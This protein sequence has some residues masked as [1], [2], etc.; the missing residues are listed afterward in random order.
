[1]SNGSVSK[2]A[3]MTA[4]ADDGAAAAATAAATAAPAAAATRNVKQ[5][6]G[7]RKH[8]GTE[9][10][11]ALKQG[12]REHGVGNWSALLTNPSIGPVLAKRSYVNLKD[13]WRSMLSAKR[14]MDPRSCKESPFDA[15]GDIAGDNAG[16][17]AEA[18]RNVK[19]VAGT[20]KHWGTEEV[21][22][23]KQG[24]RE[25]GVGNWSALLT[26]PSI[27]PV[28]AKR[29]YVNLK[30][31]WRSMLNAK[32]RMDPRSCKESPFDAAGDIAGDNAGDNAE[33]SR[34]DTFGTTKAFRDEAFRN[35]H[36]ASSDM[37][38]K[39]C[40][41]VGGSSHADF[42][43]GIGKRA[44]VAPTLAVA[45]AAG[46]ALAPPLQQHQMQQ[47]QM[48][49]HQM[50]QHRMQQQA[51][52]G[53]A[54]CCMHAALCAQ[55]DA[56]AR[57][58][59]IS[60]VLHAAQSRRCLACGAQSP[61]AI[62]GA[63]AATVSLDPRRTVAY[64]PGPLSGAGAVTGGTGTRVEMPAAAADATSGAVA[65]RAGAVAPGQALPAASAS[66]RP[67]QQ[68]QQQQQ[69]NRVATAAWAW[70]GPWPW[71]WPA[72]YNPYAGRGRQLAQSYMPDSAQQQLHQ[73]LPQPYGQ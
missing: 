18:T 24:V 39:R 50:Q 42:A 43:G 66:T 19:Q 10:V 36:S 35:E 25:H 3:T 7:T 21:L 61:T 11:L 53:R 6:A 32:R 28:L 1:V 62:S 26:N 20:R 9:E 16:D 67:Q 64:A 49:Q 22:A 47:H 48:Q 44:R 38:S 15:A 63:T 60:L 34:A 72:P 27:G 52:L 65:A 8:W 23:L 54:I 40:G 51:V 57:A 41:A 69:S 59:S 37:K 58:Y 33:A 46:T 17:V 56:L 55:R 30:D 73:Q 70:P 4:I 68:Q 71:T 14:R 29:S 31:K 13:K 5:V 45:S 12:V 2:A